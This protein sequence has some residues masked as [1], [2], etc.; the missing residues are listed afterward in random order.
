MKIEAWSGVAGRV[1]LGANLLV[2]FSIK[3]ML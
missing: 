1:G 2:W 3:V